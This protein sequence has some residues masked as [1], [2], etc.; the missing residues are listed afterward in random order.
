MRPFAG[1]SETTK[2][3]FGVPA[4]GVIAA[5]FAASFLRPR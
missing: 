3:P 1:L 4:T 2:P 5:A